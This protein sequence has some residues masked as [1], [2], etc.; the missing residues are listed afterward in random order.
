MKIN[1]YILLGVVALFAASCSNSEQESNTHQE[2]PQ[3]HDAHKQEV[4]FSKQQFE[5][6]DMKIDTLQ[7]RD[8]GSYVAANGELEVPPQNEAAVTAIIGANITKI[9]VIEGEKITKGEV[10]AYISHPDLIQLQTNYANKWNEL[11][12]LKQEYNRQKRLYEEKVGSGKEFQKIKADYQSMKSTV[13]GLT[14]QLKLLHLSAETIRNG[15]IIEHIGIRSPING[16][17]RLVEIKTG[18]YVSPQ[19]ELF[20]IVN[21]DHIHADLMVFEKD[22]HKVKEGQKVRFRL[23]AAEDVELEAEIYT[24]GK[25]FESDPKAIHLHAEI[26]NKV[27][28]L[29]PGMYVRGEI[30]IDNV[31]TYALPESAVV[32]EGGKYFIFTATA[33]NSEWAFQPIEVKT[34]IKDNGWVEIKLLEPIDNQTQLAWNNAYYLMAEMKKGENE[35]SH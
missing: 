9:M 7:K 2:E 25:N 17:V 28:L 19:T 32:S 8:M 33:E 1:I 26:E 23:E 15:N 31:S 6:M 27:G 24:V 12:Y 5:S 34:G 18:Q 4:H 30:L 35:H 13:N 21:I 3:A 16:Y 14:A 22:I 10:L 20:E 29:L 11:Q